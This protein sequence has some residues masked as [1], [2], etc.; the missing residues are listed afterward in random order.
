MILRGEPR[1]RSEAWARWPW[2][3]HHHADFRSG[4]LAS[5][6]PP[7]SPATFRTER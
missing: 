7:L 3:G 2:H 5:S 1:I 4:Q 6:Y